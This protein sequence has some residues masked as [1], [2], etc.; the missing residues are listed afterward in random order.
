MDQPQ[1]SSRVRFN[2]ASLQKTPAQINGHRIVGYKPAPLYDANGMIRLS[3][4]DIAI[5]SDEEPQTALVLHT[6]QEDQGTQLSSQST[7]VDNT[8]PQTPSRSRWGFGSLLNTASKFVP[9]LGRRAAPATPSIQ[10]PIAATPATN[11]TP[12]ILR[13]QHPRTE[14]HRNTKDVG[15]DQGTSTIER[16][17]STRPNTK[18]S[19][20]PQPNKVSKSRPFQP[21][22][23]RQ[24]QRRA[25][26]AEAALS[27]AE[28]HK[29]QLERIKTQKRELDESVAEQK[30]ILEEEQKRLE[31]DVTRDESEAALKAVEEWRAEKEANPGLKRKRPASPKVIPNPK[32]C[33]FGFDPRYFVVDDYSSDEEESSSPTSP[34]P[35]RPHKQPRLSSPPVLEG[36]TTKAQPYTGA[37]F[38]DSTPTHQGGNVFG[39][40]AV[41]TSAA[42]KASA[43]QKSVAATPKAAKTPK[44]PPKTAD[45]HIITN[46]SGHFTIPDDDS[47]EENSELLDSAS[48]QA[49]KTVDKDA[50]STSKSSAPASPQPAAPQQ[51]NQSPA[52]TGAVHERSSQ[53][54][55]AAASATAA[56]KGKAPMWSQPPPAAPSPSHAT[57]PSL[58]TADFDS[59]TAARAKAL[60]HAPKKPSTLR[61]SSRINS[62][63]LAPTEVLADPSETPVPTSPTV[64]RASSD[65][66]IAEM[67]SSVANNPPPPLEQVLGVLAD[68]APNGQGKVRSDINPKTLQLADSR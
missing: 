43:F 48:P 32:G 33:S 17:H 47:D 44:S 9:G 62:S 21:R 1:A 6:G 50:T 10:R 66:V 68:K 35:E 18:T 2:D 12:Q 53:P 58:P 42:D 23:M 14:P 34:T 55:S 41:S 59:L 45:G 38:S 30:R 19:R 57:L 51:S 36:D 5:Y 13:A 65:E 60:K 64:R 29:A 20:P 24:A 16:P 15:S 3:Q 31:D 25:E 4:P 46:L 49:D 7:L 28:R 56:D 40:L 26:Q 22:E 37:F 54:S 39:E 63:P 67:E 52:A 8:L 61:E 11:S 27:E